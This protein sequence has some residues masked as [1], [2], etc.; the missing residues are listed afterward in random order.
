MPITE[1]VLK[2]D[3]D[4]K[5]N[6]ELI[7]ELSPPNL[8]PDQ[9]PLNENDYVQQYTSELNT[10]IGDDYSIETPIFLE[11]GLA[12]SR[13]TSF[14]INFS[15]NRIEGLR[16]PLANSK[17]KENTMHGLGIKS[18]RTNDEIYGDS[19]G[20]ASNEIFSK[21]YT[22]SPYV[23]LTFKNNLFYYSFF[24]QIILTNSA[25]YA[26]FTFLPWAIA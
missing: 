11:K 6:P 3:N 25:H 5:T 10:F 8:L 21:K 7:S 4:K 14:A 15:I 9:L 2:T 24:S 23:R 1:D 13:M 18:A 22:V 17:N 26:P 16:L 19:Y 20:E 12:K